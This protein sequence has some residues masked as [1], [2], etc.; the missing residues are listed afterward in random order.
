MSNFNELPTTGFLRLASICSERR[1]DRLDTDL[2]SPAE[3]GSHHQGRGDTTPEL[4]TP[5]R[6]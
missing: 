4:P 1:I 5:R 3:S 6:R 2:N